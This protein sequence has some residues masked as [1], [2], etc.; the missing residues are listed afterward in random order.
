MD[1][2]RSTTSMNCLWGKINTS[3]YV[4]LGILM[5]KASSH[6]C[7]WV[8][9]ARTSRCLVSLASLGGVPYRRGKRIST[10]SVLLDASGC[11][12]RRLKPSPSSDIR[13]QLRH[14]NAET[15]RMRVASESTKS[16][17]QATSDSQLQIIPLCS[18]ETVTSQEGEDWL[19]WLLRPHPRLRHRGQSCCSALPSLWTGCRAPAV[20]KAADHTLGSHASSKV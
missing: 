12:S 14:A 18:V 5:L 15:R 13:V 6:E 16:S 9:P 10:I 20:T 7:N 8:C 1:F 11:Q 3:K 2:L 19:P 4:S 17:G